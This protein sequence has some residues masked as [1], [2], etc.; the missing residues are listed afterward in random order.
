MTYWDILFDTDP[1]QRRD[2]DRLE[3]ELSVARDGESLLQE[4]LHSMRGRVNRLELLCEGLVEL[5]KTRSLVDDAQLRLAIQRLDLADGV[6]DG[7]IGPDRTE[8]APSCGEC[9]RPVNPKRRDCLYCGTAIPK[10]AP[11]RPKKVRMARCE[12]CEASV[13]ERSTWITESG[14]LCDPCHQNPG[15]IGSLSLSDSEGGG[16]SEV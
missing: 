6:E 9:D 16:L 15:P 12:R 13:P 8:N 14:I 10:A 5:L 4:Q 3:Q 2:I 7:R 11:R 1:A